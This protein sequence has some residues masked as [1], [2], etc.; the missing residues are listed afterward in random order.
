MGSCRP[1]HSSIR[2]LDIDLHM[3]HWTEKKEISLLQGYFK[4]THTFLTRQIVL[5]L[6]KQQIL[7][8]SSYIVRHKIDRHSFEHQIRI[9]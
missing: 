1:V 7:F 3:E 2:T 4:C 5:S 6:L 8:S 9:D